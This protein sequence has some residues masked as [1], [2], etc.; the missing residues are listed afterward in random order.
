MNI[1]INQ[2]IQ[3][4]FDIDYLNDNYIEFEL[5]HEELENINIKYYIVLFVFCKAYYRYS[6]I[7]TN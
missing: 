6:L 4:L 1:D 5:Y 2:N 3:Y 7:R